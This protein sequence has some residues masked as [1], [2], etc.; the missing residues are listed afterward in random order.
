MI[1]RDALKESI[2]KREEM[3]NI[4]INNVLQA[5]QEGITLLRSKVSNK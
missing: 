2:L 3:K 1:Y 4:E 5:R